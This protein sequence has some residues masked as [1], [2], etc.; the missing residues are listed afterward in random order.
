MSFWV[1]LYFAAALQAALLGLALWRQPA[2]RAANRLLAVWVALTGIDL[3]VKALYWHLLT[4]E[5][6]RA[7][8][9]WRCSRSSTA[10]CSTCTCAR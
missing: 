3:A 7:Y 10:A 2:N 6:F 1:F 9:S 4:P 8:R 5:W